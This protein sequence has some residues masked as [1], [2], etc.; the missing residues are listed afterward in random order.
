MPNRPVIETLATGDEVVRGDVVDTDSAYVSQRL[1]ES[2]LLVARHTAVPDTFEEILGVIREISSRA[3]LCIGSGGLGPTGDDLTADVSARALGVG[4]QFDATAE[5]RMRERFARAGYRFTENNRRSTR[6][7]QGAQVF[8]N[9]VGTAPAFSATIDR[10]RFFF[11][12][13]V[14][15]EFRY[16]VDAHVVPWALAR[17]PGGFGAVVQLK[18][19]GWGESHLAERFED[20]AQLF[21]EV[22]VGYRAHSPEV[23]LKLT[24]EAASREAALSILA[25]AAA[26]ARRRIGDTVFGRDREELDTLAHEALLRS[27]KTLAL[28]ESCTGGL[29]ASM[30]T[31]HPGA[32]RYLLA[33]FVTYS[34]EAKTRDLGVAA[35]TLAAHGAVS[36]ETAA[37]MARGARERTGA[38]I[39][40]SITGIAGPDGGTPNKPVGLVY[41]AVAAGGGAPAVAEHRFRG[42]RGRIQRAAAAHALNLILKTASPAPG[43]G[44]P[45]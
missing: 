28:A 36:G 4:V 7:P 25:P 29:V 3:D 5:A 22:Q 12:P 31:R 14:P 24:A 30:L 44:D 34:N 21:P 43:H 37:A 15:A 1:A 20:F 40:V 18:T 16:F 13:G 26:E 32:S 17:W 42:D 6:V 10:C 35:G 11:L 9:E 41:L 8:Q 38:D 19:L 2:G 39:G 45:Q 33:G 23:W 27:G